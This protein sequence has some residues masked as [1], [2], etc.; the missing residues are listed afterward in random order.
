MGSYAARGA[1]TYRET[2]VGMSNRSYGC[3]RTTGCASAQARVDL[4][5]NAESGKLERQ[6]LSHQAGDP[7]VLF[8]V[9]DLG[10][11]LGDGDAGFERDADV[12]GR[13]ARAAGM[14]CLNL[15]RGVK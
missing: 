8:A 3:F 13:Q 1:R 4:Y 6:V 10:R 5:F 9:G 15:F 7:C 14:G 2:G 12:A 11:R